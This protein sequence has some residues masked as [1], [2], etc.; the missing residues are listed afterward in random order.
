MKIFYSDKY[1]I[2]LPPGH[3]FPITKYK[4]IKDGLLS[5]G[6]IR[7]DELFECP[8]ADIDC[9]KLAHD[10]AYVDAV[11]ECRLDQKMIRKIGFPQTEA[12]PLRS[13]ATVGGAICAAEEALENGISGNLAGGTHH[14]FYDSG[15]GFCVFND[16]AIVIM[17]LLHQ[18]K[19]KRVA[20][21]DLDVHQG[22]GNAAMLAD[23]DNVF[24]FSMHGAHNYPFKKVPSTLDIELPDNADDDYVLSRL[25]KHFHRIIDFEPDIILYQ[26]GSDMLKE[27][28][29][30]RVAMTLDG[31]AQR[32]RFV[33]SEAKRH[34]IP[35]SLGQGGGY[36]KPIEITVEAHIQTYA[37][38]KDVYELP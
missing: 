11:I 13:L 29:F 31:L 4:L 17:N 24:I 9:V 25:Y 36:A 16:F 8:L 1:T 30:G 6:V 38:L 20:I 33:F 2:P 19:V 27:D 28:A 34:G 37:I 5:R 15:E 3:K 14:A 12:L 18:R 26:H 22:N 32:D 10:P 7:S 21:L 35:M 23:L